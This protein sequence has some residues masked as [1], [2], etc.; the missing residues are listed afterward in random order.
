MLIK[1]SAKCQILKDIIKE[2]RISSRSHIQLKTETIRDLKVV[3]V[4]VS[5]FKTL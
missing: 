5:R 3:C 1:T 2:S 4:C